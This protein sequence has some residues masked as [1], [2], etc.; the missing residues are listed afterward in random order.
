[1]P[2]K[3]QDLCYVRFAITASKKTSVPMHYQKIGDF[4]QNNKFC[5]SGTPLPNTE[6]YQHV[7][8][9]NVGWYKIS[10]AG[11][12]ALKSA[13]TYARRALFRSLVKKTYRLNSDT[14]YKMRRLEA[15]TDLLNE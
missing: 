9:K 11:K 2:I 8:I 14:R 5:K 3:N 4:M 7:F 10:L 15:L 12:R 13:I 6:E 1:M